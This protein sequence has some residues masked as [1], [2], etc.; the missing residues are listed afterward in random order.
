[1][2]LAVNSTTLWSVIVM[3]FKIKQLRLCP[4]QLPCHNTVH[5]LLITSSCGVQMSDSHMCTF[6]TIPKNT[7]Q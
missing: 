6:P 2:H 7:E 4:K 5:Y 1:M 3:P